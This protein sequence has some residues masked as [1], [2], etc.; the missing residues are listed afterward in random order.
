[1]TIKIIDKWDNKLLC[2]WAFGKKKLCPVDCQ[3]WGHI[4]S[5]GMLKAE[6]QPHTRHVLRILKDLKLFSCWDQE[7]VNSASKLM[8]KNTNKT[9]AVSIQGPSYEALYR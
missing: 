7:Q 1:M 5:G 2:P 6:G 4:T 8:S 9:L 3:N